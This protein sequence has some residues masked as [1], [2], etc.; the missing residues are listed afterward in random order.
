MARLVGRGF[1]FYGHAQNSRGAARKTPEIVTIHARGGI[2]GI[3]GAC[4]G[5]VDDLN[6]VE[7]GLVTGTPVGEGHDSA[8]SEKLSLVR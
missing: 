3:E 4:I 8:P 1:T 7:R 5:V 6:D 2:I